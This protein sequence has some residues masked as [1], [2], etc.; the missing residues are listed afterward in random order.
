MYANWDRCVDI[1]IRFGVFAL[2]NQ[3]LL[4]W[5]RKYVSGKCGRFARKIIIA[6]FWKFWI[7]VKQ[8]PMVE[9]VFSVAVG[10]HFINYFHLFTISKS[11]W[12][13]MHKL[14]MVNLWL[15]VGGPQR[16]FT[17]FRNNF[18]WC[19]PMF[20]FATHLALTK[21]R[22]TGDSVRSTNPDSNKQ[23]IILH[24][25]ILSDKW[26]MNSWWSWMRIERMQARIVNWSR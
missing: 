21:M 26:L 6:H 19:A 12:A 13:K 16:L 2:I 15:A 25:H 20:D 18:V 3:N 9:P 11:F 17:C 5:M 10:R 14:P 23:F 8:L 24:I 7:V 4:Q 1:R 22:T